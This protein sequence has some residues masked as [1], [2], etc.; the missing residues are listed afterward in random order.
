MKEIILEIATPLISGVIAWFVAKYSAKA[1]IKKLKMTWAHE[2][3]C[4]AD[5]DFD[6]MVSAVSAF[7]QYSNLHNKLNAASCASVYRS[8][9]SGELAAAVDALCDAIDRASPPQAIRARL[10]EVVNLKRVMDC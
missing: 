7:L 3:E 5:D 6:N 10:N 9:V 4:A 8:K 2:K 1:E